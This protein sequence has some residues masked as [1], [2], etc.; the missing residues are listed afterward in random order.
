MKHLILVVLGLLVVSSAVYG[1]EI[2][3]E[4]LANSIKK[5]ENSKSKPYG[6]LRDYCKAGDIDG[7]CRKGC[8]QTIN[9]RLKMWRSEGEPGD[10]ISYMSKSYCP[11][12]A[13][14]DPKGLNKNWVKNVTHFYNQK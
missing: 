11:I 8:I 5:A 6:I 10:F 14:N 13:S 1:T 7:Q 4:K 2:D 12:G 3:V 9:K